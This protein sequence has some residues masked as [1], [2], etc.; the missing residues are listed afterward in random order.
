[1]EDSSSP[2]CPVKRHSHARGLQ[3]IALETA[4]VLRKPF[5]SDTIAPQFIEALPEDATVECDAVPTP[6]ILTADDNCDEVV[7]WYLKK[8]L[9]K[10]SVHRPI[11]SLARGLRRIVRAMASN[12]FKPLQFKTP[13]LLCSQKRLPTK[14]INAKNSPTLLSVNNCGAVTITESREV[15]SEDECGNYDTSLP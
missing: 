4:S 7:K 5:V 8:P 12:T 15:I 3:R 2:D 6:V 1:M 9:R 10:D 13:Y 11:P 14:S